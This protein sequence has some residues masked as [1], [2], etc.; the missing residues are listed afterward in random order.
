[1]ISL[2]TLIST[3]FT[4]LLYI[5]VISRVGQNRI[6][7]PYMTVYLLISLHKIPYIHR[8][9]MVLANPSHISVCTNVASL[10]HHLNHLNYGW[11]RAQRHALLNLSSCLCV[12]AC[13]Q[14]CIATDL[15]RAHSQTHINTHTRMQ[16]NTHTR[17]YTLKSCTHAHT[18]TI[19]TYPH[20]HTHTCKHTHNCKHIHRYFSCCEWPSLL[21]PPPQQHQQ[22]WCSSKRR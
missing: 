8:I 1:M 6:Y 17:K 5:S 18:H 3:H 10:Y 11:F 19:H 12:L 2:C 16:T 9:Y 21:P 13:V 4:F 20:T 22:R 15:H 7:T 14:A